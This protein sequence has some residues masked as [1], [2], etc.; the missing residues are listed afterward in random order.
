LL[1]SNDDWRSN[2]A[3]VEA[4]GIPPSDDRESAIVATLR[5]GNYT[6]I[7]NGKNGATGVGLVEV[8]DIGAHTNSQLANIST[9]SFVDV[10]DNVLIGGFI[11][12]FTGMQTQTRVLFRAIG[13]SLY[14]SGIPNCLLDPVLDLH[15]ANGTLIESNDN[16][17]DADPTAITA[18]G[19]A[20]SMDAESAILAMLSAG[21]YTAIVHGKGSAT[22]VAL[23][24]AYELEN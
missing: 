18:T 3:E 15:D 19:L 10:G 20:P 11:V 4:T 13:P 8:Y 6:A 21:R 7:V 2:Q 23:V 1:A 22:G 9:R 17:H 16:W 5:A 12:G 24:E 14:Y